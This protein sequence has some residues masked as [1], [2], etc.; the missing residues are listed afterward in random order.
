M[1]TQLVDPRYPR[2]RDGSLTGCRPTSSRRVSRSRS[3]R[4]S[5]ST[6]WTSPTTRCWSAGP[7]RTPTPSATGGENPHVN[8]EPVDHWG[9]EEASRPGAREHGPTISGR[10]TRAQ[11]PRTND[12]VQAGQRYLL[13]AQWEKDDLVTNLIT[14]LGQ[15]D[16]PIQ[17]R[18]V[19]H[20][21]MAEDELGL[22]VGQGLGIK[23]GDV[24][25]LEPL[26]RQVFTD[27]ERERLANLGEGCVAL[28]R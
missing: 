10:L 4:A 17:E 18:M 2:P 7:S 28:V 8:Y 11:I 9:A 13:S 22:L 21:L 26:P 27:E 25:H 5:W 3:G 6:A 14:L 20:L 24:R 19:W 15:C 1:C 12:Y 23:P 16:R